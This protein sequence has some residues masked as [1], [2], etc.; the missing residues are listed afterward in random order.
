MSQKKRTRPNRVTTPPPPA[1]PMPPLARSRPRVVD[2]SRDPNAHPDIPTFKV[3]KPNWGSNS[4]E[5]LRGKLELAWESVGQPLFG[6]IATRFRRKPRYVSGRRMRRAGNL[7]GWSWDDQGV[8]MARRVSRTLLVVGISAAVLVVLAAGTVRLISAFS[9]IHPSINLGL[10]SNSDT[11]TPQGAISIRNTGGLDDGTPVG[12]PA[13]T[14]GMWA[15]NQ[16]PVGGEPIT[17]Y[18][19]VSHYSAG[20]P[21]VPV[22]FSI[23]GYNSTVYTDGNG[24]AIWRIN[25]NGPANYPVEIDGAVTVGGQNLTASTFYSII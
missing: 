20:V 3:T 9:G 8:R 18:A 7:A 4:L 2:A 14:F 22:V 5:W 11:P 25:A 16:E 10:G 13:Y 1:T 23:G 24:L 12:I 15:S 6:W 19:K 21:G 17:I